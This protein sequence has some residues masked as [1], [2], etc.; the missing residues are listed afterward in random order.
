MRSQIACSV[1][2]DTS[3]LVAFRDEWVRLWSEDQHATPFQSPEWLLPWWHH[4]GQPD[5]RAV[6][7]TQAGEV[8]AFL[9]FYVYQ[10]PSSGQRKILLIGAGT[11]DYLDGIFTANCTASHVAAGMECLLRSNDWDVIDAMQ[12]RP[13]S[14]LL[15]YFKSRDAKQFP[16]EP[17]SGMAAVPI[18]NLHTKIRRNFL[19]Y[20]NRASRMGRL[21]LV[22]ADASNCAEAFETLVA[23]HTARWQSACEPGVL[24]DQAVLGWHREAI[25]LLQ[26]SNLLRL[27]T[28]RL[29]QTVIASM[30]SLVDPPRRVNRTEYVYL[31]AFSTDYADL[32]PG[33]LLLGLSI[34][35]AAREGIQVID[36]LRGQEAYKQIWHVE[37]IPTYGFSMGNPATARACA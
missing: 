19:Y 4:F 8:I 33:T 12:L 1:L 36:M 16:A 27:N 25:P 21:E 10:E 2:K 26:A 6:I 7:V 17:C 23:L 34:D 37:Q 35:H 11:S 3:E 13:Q 9:P 20:R 28:L 32:R 31:P 30:Y 15:Q 18:E 14:L 22:I 24:A 29:N 5:L